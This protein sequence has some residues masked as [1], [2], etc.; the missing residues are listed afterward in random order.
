MILVIVGFGIST[1]ILLLLIVLNLAGLRRSFDLL[2]QL[3]AIAIRDSGLVRTHAEVKSD[4][5]EAGMS[6][7]EEAAQEELERTSEAEL[8]TEEAL[9]DRE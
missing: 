9:K 8:E 2:G 1:T 3:V 6:D 7:M 4:M 5:E